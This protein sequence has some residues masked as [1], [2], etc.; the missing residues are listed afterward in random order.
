MDAESIAARLEI[1]TADAR[2]P[3]IEHDAAGSVMR[4]GVEKLLNRRVGADLKADSRKQ[5][6]EGFA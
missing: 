4:T 1:E 5:Q 2:Q 6:A 3:D